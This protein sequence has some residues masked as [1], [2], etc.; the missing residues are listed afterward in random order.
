MNP[1]NLNGPDFLLFYGI[2]LAAAIFAVVFVRQVL[3]R[4]NVAP[5]GARGHDLDPFEVAYLAGG[6]AR[7]VQAA[8]VALANRKAV[9]AGPGNQLS[10]GQG[11]PG[12]TSVAETAVL[13]AVRRAPVSS[14]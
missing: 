10:A 5:T 6:P 14:F 1:L 2:T 12:T 8:L 13:R 4:G 3:G 7:T 9:V 11:D